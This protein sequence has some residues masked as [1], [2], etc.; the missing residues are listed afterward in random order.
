MKNF[1]KKYFPAEAL[2][3]LAL[4]LL[5]QAI[6]YFIPKFFVEQ[7]WYFKIF[8][9]T[10]EF[11]IKTP[12]VPE[13]IIV[14]LGCF[15]FWVLGIFFLYQ[16]KDRKHC[17]DIVLSVLISHVICMIIYLLIPTTTKLRPD[18]NEYE[19]KTIFDFFVKLT[20]SSDS[21][22]NLFPSMHCTV[23]WFCVMAIRGR[24]EISLGYRIFSWIF[25]FMIF[26]SILL[27]KQHY[28]WDILPSLILC[29]I[30]YF[31]IKKTSLSDKL[32][33]LCFKINRLLKLDRFI[34]QD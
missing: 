5:F 3:P 16:T 23:T 24:K 11:D 2:V 4:I 31:I 33:N 13:A 17:Y 1:I 9:F 6:C 30:I 32:K 34:E 18:I 21:P 26:A 27:T 7:G 22:Y 28:V 29:E 12:F 20:Y 19:V 8:D 25:S 15:V 14:Y 10:T